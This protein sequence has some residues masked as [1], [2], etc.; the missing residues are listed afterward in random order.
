MI[1]NLASVPFLGL[2]GWGAVS[3]NRKYGVDA[4]SGATIQINRQAL[5]ELK[6]TLPKGKIGNHEM[7]NS[8]WEV[9]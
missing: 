4:L 1:R 6:G 2:M 9:T 8:F 5:G 3:T 7:S